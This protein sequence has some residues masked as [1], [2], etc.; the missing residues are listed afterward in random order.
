MHSS[1]VF[2]AIDNI[3]N[4]IF[5]EILTLNFHNINN[6]NEMLDEQDC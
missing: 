6:N 5:I 3:N 2:S 1:Q 4:K